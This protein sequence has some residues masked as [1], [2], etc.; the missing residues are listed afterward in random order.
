[1]EMKSAKMSSSVN[2]KWKI[3]QF[4]P[5]AQAGVGQSEG[6]EISWCVEIMRC[7]R[8]SWS[9]LTEGKN[10]AAEGWILVHDSELGVEK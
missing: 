2:G 1:M 10:T 4:F 9:I 5:S 6:T 8:H 3:K 7:G